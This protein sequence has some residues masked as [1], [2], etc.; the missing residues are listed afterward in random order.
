MLLGRADGID[1]EVG[2]DLRSEREQPLGRIRGQDLSEHRP[3]VDG[4]LAVELGRHRR[5]PL[6]VERRG[7]EPGRDRVAI[8]CKGDDLQRVLPGRVGP[9]APGCLVREVELQLPEELDHRQDVDELRVGKPQLRGAGRD[10]RRIVRPQGHILR[11]AVVEEGRR[12][13]LDDAAVERADELRRDLDARHVQPRPPAEQARVLERRQER[14]V[15]PW[16]A[17]QR[18]AE[19]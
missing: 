1:H 4:I 15:L 16:Q 11:E 13:V 5:P 18:E 10:H 6:I 12:H 9:I 2:G 17:H 19:V 14:G 7:T 3:H 8:R